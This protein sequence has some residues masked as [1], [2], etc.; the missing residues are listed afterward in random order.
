VLSYEDCHVR[1][2]ASGALVS[3]VVA[4]SLGGDELFDRLAEV[5]EQGDRQGRDGAAWTLMKLGDRRAIPLLTAAFRHSDPDFALTI[6]RALI[7]IG[8]EGVEALVEA[9]GSAEAE[10][11]LRDVAVSALE[12]RH[13]PRAAERV[14]LTPAQREAREREREAEEV[15]ALIR[16]L[17]AAD[18]DYGRCAAEGLVGIAAPAIEPLVS[19]VK[20]WVSRPNTGGKYAA[21]H[22]IYVLEN[23]RDSRAVETMIGELRGIR[24]FYSTSI[25]E[26]NI[27]RLMERGISAPGA[28]H[29]DADVAL[30]IALISSLGEIGDRRAVPAI[31]EWDPLG[32][33]SPRQRRALLED[34]KHPAS[35]DS[36]YAQMWESASPLTCAWVDALHK[37]GGAEAHAALRGG[38]LSKDE[39]A[40]A[41][42][43]ETERA[44]SEVA[45]REALELFM[46]SAEASAEEAAHVLA[47]LYDRSPYRGGWFVKSDAPA[48]PVREVGQRL[49][50][51][52]GFQLMRDAYDLFAVLRPAMARNLEMVW[53]DTGTWSG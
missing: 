14:P 13:H 9:A 34:R 41:D 17:T 33:W 21:K 47:W 30:A 44:A 12:E 53:D 11:D 20:Q 3:V 19:W 45:E 5:L 1:F 26:E 18:F 43:E 15:E 40:R 48:E 49:Y 24:S 31:V 38:T 28:A 50:Q 46:A 6:A 27:G 37:L 2:A 10:G 32:N 7:D 16:A 42:R 25:T 51:H 22:A 23:V 52:G 29:F 8:D 39:I 4:G 35:A 36:G